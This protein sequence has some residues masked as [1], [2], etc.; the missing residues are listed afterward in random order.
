M[1]SYFRLRPRGS[2]REATWDIGRATPLSVDGRHRSPVLVNRVIPHFVDPAALRRDRVAALLL[3]ASIAIALAFALLLGSTLPERR[4]TRIGISEVVHLTDAMK[5][6]TA[7]ILDYD[8]RIVL[9][10][11]DGRTLW[12]QLPS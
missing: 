5:V 2:R 12:A 3:A 9:R 7:T 11:R 4:G 10:V 1:A 6:R 8:H